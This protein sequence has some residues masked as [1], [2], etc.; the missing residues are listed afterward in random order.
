VR[1]LKP[2]R[3]NHNLH[4]RNTC[5]DAE[6]RCGHYP[7]AAIHPDAN[8]DGADDIGLD[9]RLRCDAEL[10]SPSDRECDTW[11]D[12]AVSGKSDPVPDGK[13]N[14]NTRGS[15][16]GNRDVDDYCGVCHEAVSS[17]SSPGAGRFTGESNSTQ[18]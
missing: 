18:Q 2:D 11:R 10:D 16:V 7:D 12:A 3:P 8:S 5:V 9:V 1:C 4:D 13:L 14:A 15:T 6:S 17:A